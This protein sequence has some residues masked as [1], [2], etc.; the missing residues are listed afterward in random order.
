MT[1]V[2]WVHSVIVRGRRW[3]FPFTLEEVTTI[4]EKT[5]LKWLSSYLHWYQTLHLKIYK[6]CIFLFLFFFF[7]FGLFRT[8][9]LTF[10]DQGSNSSCSHQPTPQPQQRQVRAVSV[11]YTTAQGNARSL[12]YWVK[13][14]IEPASSWMLVR[15]VAAEPR[16]VAPPRLRISK[17]AF[18]EE[19]LVKSALG[20]SLWA[21]RRCWLRTLLHALEVAIT[22]IFSC[23]G[24]FVIVLRDY[25]LDGLLVGLSSETACLCIGHSFNDSR[26][27]AGKYFK[28]AQRSPYFSA[29]KANGKWQLPAKHEWRW[30]EVQLGRVRSVTAQRHVAITYVDEVI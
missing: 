24:D 9:L 2:T 29:W 5:Y 6:D 20:S 18:R 19:S 3:F 11:T 13:S 23:F 14:G 10:S 30:R 17:Q 25:S 8:A 22:L 21:F 4:K 15:F 28:L 16:T 1:K 27:K 7:F 26:W 12:T